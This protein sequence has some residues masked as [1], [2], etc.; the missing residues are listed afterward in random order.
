MFSQNLDTLKVC[1]LWS[2][3]LVRNVSCKIGLL[4]AFSLF[5]G[6]IFNPTF[7]NCIRSFGRE[8]ANPIDSIVTIRDNLWVLSFKIVFIG[9]FSSDEALVLPSW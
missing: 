3:S 7:Q 5:T 2:D 8:N 4:A 1:I 6:Q 9:H